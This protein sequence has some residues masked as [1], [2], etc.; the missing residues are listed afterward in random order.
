MVKHVFQDIKGI[1]FNEPFP[2]MTWEDAME[3]YGNDKPDIRF[4]MKLVNFTD[5]VKGQGFKVFDEAELV[6]AINAKGQS[7]YTRKQL[8]ELTNW[9]K[10]P[11]IGMSGLIYVRY[12]T[13]SSTKVCVKK[14]SEK[15]SLT[16]G[17]KNAPAQPGDLILV[18]AGREERT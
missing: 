9:V 10:R 15:P 13:A 14:F 6:V 17:A 5:L 2:R 12:N 4:E 8:D 18:L 11:Q 16:A 3:F 7:E 1:T